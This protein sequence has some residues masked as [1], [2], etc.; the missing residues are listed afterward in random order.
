MRHMQ[1]KT[2]KF[3]TKILF[4]VYFFETIIHLPTRTAE[5]TIF[6]SDHKQNKKK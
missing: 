4:S 2:V 1:T 5:R 3:T 6:K